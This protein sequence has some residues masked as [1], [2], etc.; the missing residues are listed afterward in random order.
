MINKITLIQQAIAMLGSEKKLAAAAG[1]SQ[2]VVNVAKKTGRVGPR[3]AVGVHKAT[4]GKISK[5][6]LRPDLFSDEA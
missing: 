4:N 5:A 3:F 1:V 2:P 6:D